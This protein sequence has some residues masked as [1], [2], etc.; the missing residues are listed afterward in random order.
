MPELFYKTKQK[1]PHFH[2]ENEYYKSAFMVTEQ[3]S[4]QVKQTLSGVIFC[5][6]DIS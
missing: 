2:P 1:L 5:F 4:S 6:N 3:P